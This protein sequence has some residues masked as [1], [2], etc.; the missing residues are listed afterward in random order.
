M[1]N[2]YMQVIPDSHFWT[3][4]K[5]LLNYLELTY[6]PIN[7]EDLIIGIKNTLK[8]GYDLR[9]KKKKNKQ[10]HSISCYRSLY[11]SINQR[12]ELDKIINAIPEYKIALEKLKKTDKKIKQL[13]L[14]KYDKIE[15][16][17][18]LKDLNIK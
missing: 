4:L 11:M 14:K 1:N 6:E 3:N 16:N 5:M 15:A 8:R 18:M 9:K 2:N 12:K 7:K 17:K 10:V 13:I